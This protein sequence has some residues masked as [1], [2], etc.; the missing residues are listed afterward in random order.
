MVDDTLYASLNIGRVVIFKALSHDGFKTSNMAH[1][2]RH[3]SAIEYVVTN[4]GIL[5]AGSGEATVTRWNLNATGNGRWQRPD[6]SEKFNAPVSCLSLSKDETLLI[7]QLEDNTVW[8]V[9]TSSMNILCEC[10]T[11][12]WNNNNNWLPLCRDPLKPDLILTGG[13]IGHIQ[14]FEPTK[15]KT[16]ASVSWFEQKI[17][18]KICFSLM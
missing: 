2:H 7:V 8:V 10:Q 15:W 4:R 1:F 12:Q 11:M 5:Y 17:N 6:N 14:W 9:Q 16:I 3:P 13:R 18:L